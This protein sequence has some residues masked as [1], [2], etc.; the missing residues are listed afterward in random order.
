MKA[1][2][3]TEKRKCSI[4]ALGA[5]AF[6][7][8]QSRLSECVRASGEVLQWKFDA[9]LTDLAIKGFHSPSF[10]KRQEF[11]A[12][13]KGKS[14]LLVNSKKQS[15]LQSPFYFLLTQAT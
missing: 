10:V 12:L 14:V 9:L 1:R 3:L 11:H 8:K 15:G 7:K 6:A 13:V 5:D 2:S 4:Q